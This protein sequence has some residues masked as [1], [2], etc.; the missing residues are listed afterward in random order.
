M[1]LLSKYVDALIKALDNN[2]YD[3]IA[4]S[5]IYSSLIKIEKF[6]KKPYGK[7]IHK[8]HLKFIRWK[9]NKAIND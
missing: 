6:A 2:D 5:A 1:N 3:E 7:E 9:I 4:R 8:N